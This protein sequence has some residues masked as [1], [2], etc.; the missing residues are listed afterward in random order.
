MASVVTPGCVHRTRFLGSMSR[1]L[2]ICTRQSTTLPSLGTLPSFQQGLFYVQDPS[3]LL[4]VQALDPQHVPDL[5]NTAPTDPIG[6]YPAW[7]DPEKI[8][9]I[10]PY[11][12][13]VAEAFHDYL[14]KGYD[15]R[16]TIAVTKAHIDLPEKQTVISQVASRVYGAGSIPFYLFQAFTALLLVLAANTS[17]NAF[18]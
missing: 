15:V 9:S 17:F 11:G 4:A 8:V 16:P 3:T 12:A 7:H 18:P 13:V 1:I 6:P 10:D 5:T 2:F 14:Q